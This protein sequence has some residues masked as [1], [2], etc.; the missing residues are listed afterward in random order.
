[1]QLLW[2]IKTIHY[3]NKATTFLIQYIKTL[4]TV[5]WLIGALSNH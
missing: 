2:K 4:A 3:K 1:M 5:A